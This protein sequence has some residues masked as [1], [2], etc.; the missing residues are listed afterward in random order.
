[1]QLKK[2]LVLVMFSS[3]ICFGQQWEIG[4]NFMFSQPA[5]TMKRDMNN[6]FG[7]TLE[8]ARRMKAPIAIGAEFNFSSYGSE[9]SRQ[10]YTFDDGSTTETNVNVHNDIFNVHLTGKYFLRNN[11]NINPYLTGKVGWSFFKTTLTIEDPEDE[12]ACHPLENDV[13]QKD[14]TYTWTVGGGVRMD[15]NAVFRNMPQQ[16]FYFDMSV[17]SI[18]GGRIRYM[19][20]EHDPSKQ[21]TP[22]QDVITKFINTQNQVIHEHHVGYVYTN[23]LNMVEY[24]LGITCRIGR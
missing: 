4:S 5:G 14:N 2:I 17:Q 10:E 16:R 21:P 19:N 3:T 24:R 13:L 22:E 12:D 23:V 9:T 20:V 6:A 11:K 1:M 18:Q 15:F 7:I 8:A